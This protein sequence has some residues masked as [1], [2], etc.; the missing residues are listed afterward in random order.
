MFDIKKMEW[1]RQP[2]DCI[3]SNEKIVITTAYGS[4]AENIL[5]FQK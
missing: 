4:L 3:L 5:S 2:K 1:L